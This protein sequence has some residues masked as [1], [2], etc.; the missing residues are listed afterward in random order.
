[1]RTLAGLS[2]SV[3]GT[4]QTRI[5]ETASCLLPFLQAMLAEKRSLANTLVLNPTRE[6][7]SNSMLLVED[8]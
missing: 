1:M 5:G 7:A 8:G 6:L 4:A 3:I 2:H